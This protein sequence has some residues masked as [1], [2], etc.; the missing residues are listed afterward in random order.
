MYINEKNMYE[1][2]YMKSFKIKKINIFIM[3]MITCFQ[4]R[5]KGVILTVE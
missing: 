3:M 1:R 4:V 5:I 2:L